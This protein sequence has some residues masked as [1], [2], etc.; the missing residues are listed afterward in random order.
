MQKTVL[1]ERILKSAAEGKRDRERLR[2][3][4]LRDFAA[5]QRVSSRL[6]ISKSP[7]GLRNPHFNIADV[8]AAMRR[9][10]RAMT[11]RDRGEYRE[12][13]GAFVN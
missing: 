13:A 9:A 7:N 12:A 4:A 10:W 1:A 11:R 6:C 2:E 3:A 8:P 5:Q